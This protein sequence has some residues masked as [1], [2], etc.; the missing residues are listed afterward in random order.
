MSYISNSLGPKLKRVARKYFSDLYFSICASALVPI[1]FRSFLWRLVGIEVGERCYLNAG[2]R[3]INKNIKLGD[4]VV[5]AYGVYI[6]AS[7]EVEI[8]DRV[9]FGPNV[10]VISANHTVMHS[11]FRRDSLEVVFCK[12]VIG[13]GVWLGSG[14]IVLPGVTIGEGCVIGAGAVV[15]SDCQPNG[16]Y[17]GVPAKRIRDLPISSE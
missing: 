11:V 15:A 8:G 6:D 7:G 5:I 10:Q 14:S 12:N 16:L 4:R 9:H 13:R 17:V 1:F 3:L 2:I